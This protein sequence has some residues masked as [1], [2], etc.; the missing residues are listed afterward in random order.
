MTI[1]L[2]L[3]AW[4]LVLALVQV[5]LPAKFRDKIGRAHV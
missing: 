4:S 1:E 3:L 5:L 2:R